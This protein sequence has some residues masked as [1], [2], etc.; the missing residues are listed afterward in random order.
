MTN[1]EQKINDAYENK[2]PSECRVIVRKNKWGTNISGINEF[3]LNSNLRSGKKPWVELSFGQAKAIFLDL[4]CH[5][6]CYGSEA[7]DEKTGKA[8]ANDY[9]AKFNPSTAKYYTDL[10]V[11]R[12][13]IPFKLRKISSFQSANILPDHLISVAVIAVDEDTI[14]VYV[15]FGYK[16]FY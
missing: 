1:I 7:I 5:S 3:L 8:Y 6:I 15:E 10:I 16:A 14:G 4:T 11:D 9:F 12:Y 13:S 2:H